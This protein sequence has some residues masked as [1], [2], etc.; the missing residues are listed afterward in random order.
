MNT[1]ARFDAPPVVEVLLALQFERME[2]F[3]PAH[4]AVF[5][6]EHLRPGWE[7][8]RVQPPIEAAVERLEPDGIWRSPGISFEAKYAPPRFQFI[9]IDRDLMLQIQDTSIILN[10]K[11]SEGRYP[12]FNALLPEFGSRLND[13]GSFLS[14]NELG[15]LRPRQWEVTYVNH[16]VMGELWSDVGEWQDVLPGLLSSPLRVRCG[17]LETMNA[18]WSWML[19][20]GRARMRVGVR[21]MRID[22]SAPQ[23]VIDLRLT[24]RGRISDML[25]LTNELWYGHDAIVHAFVELTSEKAHA[26]WGRTQ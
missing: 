4:A 6:H 16:L 22:S 21:H 12:S 14:R 11:R 5:W 19:D 17:N 3:T 25:A 24:T 10:W 2:R 8:V 7:E 1:P 9:D 20:A 13:F 15:T 26:T 23:E 18:S